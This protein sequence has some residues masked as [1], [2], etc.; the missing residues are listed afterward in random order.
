MALSRYYFYAIE[1]GSLEVTGTEARHIV[2]VM[3]FG[4]S[5]YL[6]LFDGKGTF[7]KAIITEVTGKKVVME[8]DNIEFSPAIASR[9]LII[10]SSI[11]KKDRFQW[12]I[13]K[14]TELGVDRISPVVFTRTVKQPKNPNIAQRYRDISISA[15]KQCRRLWLP[16]IDAPKQLTDVHSM[17]KSEYPDAIVLACSLGAEARSLSDISF[18]RD[19]IAYIGPEGGFTD[20]EEQFLLEEGSYQVKLTE[21]VLR[22]ETAAIAFAA[23]FAI[24]RSR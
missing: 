17:L 7:A 13:T 19:I 16:Q 1:S 24:V 8:V 18:D 3:R 20:Q 4:V 21:T 5:D 2:R 6:E 11:A 22:T 15:A 10:A 23:N 9:R 14:C 12:L